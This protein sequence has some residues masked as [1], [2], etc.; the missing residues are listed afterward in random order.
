MWSV[1]WLIRVGVLSIESGRVLFTN[2][3]LMGGATIGK[4]PSGSSLRKVMSS[5]PCFTFTRETGVSL[6]V[7]IEDQWD[8]TSSVDVAIT[9]SL[10]PY[11]RN[12]PGPSIH[13][14]ESPSHR[15]CSMVLIRF[16]ESAS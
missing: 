8:L 13:C 5:S 10:T 14:L 16:L 1:G 15:D 7:P 9:E 3:D 11:T 4:L 12:L 2:G 6:T